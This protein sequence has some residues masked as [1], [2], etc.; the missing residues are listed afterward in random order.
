M[1]SDKILEKEKYELTIVV[2]CFNEEKFIAQ[3]LKCVK[4]ALDPL[5]IVYEVI[6]IDDCSV[7]RTYENAI[8]YKSDNPNSHVRVIQ[9]KQNRG[10][11]RSYCDAAFLGVGKYFR[12]V[13]GDNSETAE[14]IQKIVKLRHT[15]DMILPYHP[16]VPG[17]SLLRRFIS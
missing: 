11:S 12:L 10:L 13:C 3:T 1:K 6:V 9:N 14:S 16:K 5:Q 4:E 15:A 17:K 2:P 8:K 7:D